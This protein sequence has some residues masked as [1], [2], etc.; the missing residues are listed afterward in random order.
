MAKQYGNNISAT[1]IPH[2]MAQLQDTD[3]SIRKRALDVIYISAD[4]SSSQGVVDE[5]IASLATA[6]SEMKESI[7]VKIAILAENFVKVHLT[8]AIFDP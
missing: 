5:L 7:V 1:Y 3:V 2:I 4:A 6:D 8:Y